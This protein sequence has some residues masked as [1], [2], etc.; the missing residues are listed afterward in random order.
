MPPPAE[1]AAATTQVA[2]GQV[3]DYYPNPAMP[4]PFMI[5]GPI[6]GDGG[7]LVIFL[8]DWRYEDTTP[9]KMWGLRDDP[10]ERID[11]Y[12]RLDDEGDE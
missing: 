11:G 6:D 7:R 2:F 8:N 5:V 12:V 1:R 4:T 3:W 10:S 9:D